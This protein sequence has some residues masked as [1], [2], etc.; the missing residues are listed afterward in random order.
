MAERVKL[1]IIRTPN[2]PVP[3]HAPHNRECARYE[4]DLHYGVIDGDK[5][6]ENVHVPR[7]EHQRVKLLSLS[8]NP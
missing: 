8:R 3:P 5:L 2:H 4:H 7:Q 6:R 1:S